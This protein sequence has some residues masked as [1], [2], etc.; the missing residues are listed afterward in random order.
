MTKQ[1]LRWWSLSA[2]GSEHPRKDFIDGAGSVDADQFVAV[3]VQQRRG[4]LSVHL[5]PGLEDDLI[6]V[7]GAGSALCARKHLVLPDV[8]TQ[9]RVDAGVAGRERPPQFRGLLNRAWVAV[10]DESVSAPIGLAEPI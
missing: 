2:Y 3:V 6:D 9:H 5:Q 10:E 8:K 1:F 4:L 7:V